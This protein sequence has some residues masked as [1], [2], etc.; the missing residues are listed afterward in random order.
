[1]KTKTRNTWLVLSVFL[2]LACI[3][4]FSMDGPSIIIDDVE[5]DG[6]AGVGI[7]IVGCLIGL[8]ATVFA[9]SL[10]G[11]VLAGVAIFLILLGVFVF[12]SVAL[13]LTPLLLPLLLVVAVIWLLGKR[14]RA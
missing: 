2:I 12:G 13:A 6:V 1:M 9:I 3:A 4:L 5:I 8:L 14:K 11:L 7:G 10:A